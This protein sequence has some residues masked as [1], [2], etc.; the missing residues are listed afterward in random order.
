MNLVGHSNIS[1]VDFFSLANQRKRKKNI[2]CLENEGLILEDNSIMLDLAMVLYKK[3]FGEENKENIRLGEDVWAEDE[4]ILR[5][6]N[7]A[8][9]ANFSEEEIRR[10]VF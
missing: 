10:A 3:L 8:P 1:I 9:E 2:S 6:E 5:E 7:E 4:K